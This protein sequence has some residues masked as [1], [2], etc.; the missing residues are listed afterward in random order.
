MP[1]SEHD[2]RDLLRERSTAVPTTPD[3][4]HRVQERVRRRRR[5]EAGAGIGALVIAL[6]ATG[7]V[8]VPRRDAAPPA[9][10]TPT[11]RVTQVL[12]STLV[13]TTE[14][15]TR[16]EGEAPFDVHLEV[17]NTG[18]STW[19]GMAG[20][21]LVTGGEV[22]GFIGENA[23]V[24][25]AEKNSGRGPF[26]GPASTQ[27]P[28]AVT[29]RSSAQQ[30]YGLTVPSQVRL[31][32]GQSGS[33]T[34]RMKR[35]P[36]ATVLDPVLGWS[37]WLDPD[38]SAMPSL[39]GSL[40]ALVP[41]TVTPRASN[42]ACDTVTVTSASVRPA[43]PWQLTEASRAVVGPDLAA[44]WLPLDVTDAPVVGVVATGDARQTTVMAAVSAHLNDTA[45]PVPA[46][47]YAS[48]G[49]PMDAREP[50]PGTYVWFAGARMAEITFK[51][52]CGPSGQPI[53]GT[54]TAYYRTMEGL[55]DCSVVPPAGSLALDAKRF[56][57][58]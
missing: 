29:D 17:T 35:D 48:G 3:L 4:A 55:L 36:S 21:G 6:V 47:G 5:L 12:G 31:E 56:C 14:G 44:T 20:V 25:P 34:M 32:P 26:D 54:W 22:P 41:V 33:W 18:S 58:L 37:P 11:H 7:L 1:V 8:V 38:G 2:L 42:L 10:T 27:G 57:K 46:T 40:G 51:G 19:N 23:L 28:A 30:W 24:V 53:S 15:P 45:T 16:I 13:V 49:N 52:T 43:G 9:S 50:V 39:Y